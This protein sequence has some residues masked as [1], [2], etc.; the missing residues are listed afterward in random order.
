MKKR[1]YIKRIALTVGILIVLALATVYIW[2][3]AIIDKTYHIPLTAIRIPKDSASI[4]EG[5]RLTHIEHC[6]DCH[7]DH[8]TGAVFAKKDHVAE[9]VAPNITRI[10]PTYSNEELERL[11]RY[12]V[13]KNGH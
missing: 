3:T 5:A 10:I 4:A 9:L 13:T 6:S 7:G 2:S 8:L 12:G 1:N 11:L